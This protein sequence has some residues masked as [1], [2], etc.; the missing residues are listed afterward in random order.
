MKL[1]S[2]AS[3]LLL[4]AAFSE[5]ALGESVISPNG[6]ISIH[7]Q[8]K[9]GAAAKGGIFWRV[10]YK[11]KI[12]MQDSSLGFTLKDAPSLDKNFSI[13]AVE[14]SDHDTSW[15]PPYGECSEYLDKYSQ[16]QV[17]VEDGK[18][19]RLVLTFRAYDEGAAMQATFPKQKAFE[20]LTIVSEDT[21]FRFTGD[22]QAWTTRK[23]Q[24][25]Y[26]KKMLSRLNPKHEYERPFVMKTS[27]GTHL[28]ILEAGLLDYARMQI[29][30]DK[31][32]PHTLVT[33]LSGSATIK[34]PYSLPW[35][36]L[37][38][39]PAPGGL[40]QNNYLLL[41]LSPPNQLADTAWIKP[42]KQCRE[43]TL[44]T[45]NSMAMIDFLAANGLDYLELD[46]G[47]YGT[48]RDEKADASTVT[49]PPYFAKN[50]PF[51]LPEIIRYAKSKNIGVVLYV[52]RIHMVKQRDELL[53]LYRKWG[54]SGIKMGFVEVG[55][56]EPT[57]WLH[58]TIRKCAEHQLFVDVHDE[59]RPTGIERTYPNFMTSEGV[60]GNEGHGPTPQQDVE[61]TFIRCLCGPT[62]FTMAWHTKRLKLSWAHQMAAAVVYYSPLQTLFWSD[63]AEK[64]T[65]KEP[66]LKYFAALPTV[67]D[68]KQVIQGEIGEFITVARRK[69]DD[70]FVGTMN[71]I[72]HRQAEI[73][74]S[75]LTPGKK[76]TAT[77]YSDPT[78]E[79][80]VVIDPNPKGK[81][82][83]ESKKLKIT[84]LEVTSKTVISANMANNG[85]HAIHIVS[86]VK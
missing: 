43:Y 71:A 57:K 68:E 24:G 65:G 81:G 12:V 85:G 78:P 46:T 45:K 86:V 16:M 27:E 73:P 26:E 5:L 34:T 14:R 69:G 7:F 56:Q 55:P 41:N 76:Y 48:E 22:H 67:W 28:A 32:T 10:D 9:D 75:F 6:D 44:T 21:Q 77:I 35:R 13:K 83:P 39:A 62:D 3:L 23:A 58:E 4:S 47:W 61:N 42:G 36:V 60:K 29:G 40:L 38:A 53:P 8:V 51:D 50:G 49:R 79:I 82:N 11:G 66:Y 33:R 18:R 54:I 63:R 31:R 37:M 19:R 20:E 25:K 2:I 15:K 84:T 59:Y 72:K 17:T 74:L 70:W 80:E 1:L 30:V 64:F 52:N